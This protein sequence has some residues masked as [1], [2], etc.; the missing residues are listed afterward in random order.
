MM[1]AWFS[2]SAC[3]SAFACVASIAVLLGSARLSRSAEFHVA[4][5]DV[6]GL[7]SAITDATSNGEDDI[8]NLAPGSTYNLSQFDNSTN[9]NAANGLPVLT[10]DGGRSLT[11]NGNGATISCVYQ[12][13]GTPF[14]AL[15]VGPSAIVTLNRLTISGGHLKGSSSSGGG[16][17]LN[18]RGQLTLSECTLSGNGVGAIQA[19]DVT[20]LLGGAIYNARGTLTLRR[21]TFF[22]NSVRQF[23]TSSSSARAAGGAIYNADGVVTALLCTFVNNRAEIDAGSGG[24]S[25]GASGGAI[26]NAVATSAGEARLTIASCTFSDNYA[27]A[28]QSSPAMPSA[29]GNAIRNT[30]AR[31]ITV[32]GSSILASINSSNSVVSNAGGVV[33]SSGFNLTSGTAEGFFTAG[34]DQINA[35]PQLRPIADNGG[36]TRTCAPRITSPV[37][38]RG[39]RDAVPELTAETDQR[40][41]GRPID[42]SGAEFAPGDGSDI[43]AHEAQPTLV[44]TTTSDHPDDGDCSLADCTLREAIRAANQAPNADTIAFASGVSGTINLTAALPDLATDLEIAGPGADRLTVRRDTGGNYRIFTVS[45]GTSPG[46]EIGLADLTLSNGQGVG[47]ATPGGGIQ[48]VSGTLRL[49]RCAI[50]GNNAGNGAGIHN[51][52]GTVSVMN[53]TFS[54][55]TAS[56]FGGALFNASTDNYSDLALINCTVVGNTSGRGAALY[57][58]AN[59]FAPRVVLRSCTFAGNASP[60]GSIYHAGTTATLNLNNTILSVPSGTASIVIVNSAKVTSEGHNISSDAAGGDGSTG[61]GGRLTHASDKRN[62]DPLLDPA[63]LQDNGGPTL[64]LALQANSPAIDTGSSTNALASDQR[65]FTRSG[66]VD[67][68]AFEFAGVEP[69][70]PP[71]P[72]PSPSATPA[73]TATPPPNRFA[74]IS[75]R[76]RVETGDNVLIGGFIVTGSMQKRIIVRALGPSLPLDDKLANPVL[77]LYDGNAQLIASNDNWQEAPNAQEIIDSTIPP[78]NEFESAI[79]R[80]VDLGAYTAVVRDAAGGEGVGL[81]EVYDL[82]NAQDSELANISTRGRV[83]TAD[84]VMIGGLIATG[85]HAQKVIL[86]AI[87]PSLP[88]A[89]RLEN[90]LLELYDGNGNL[91]SANDNWKDSQQADIEATTIPPS[92]DFESA[93]V[94]FLPPAAYTAIV[95]G[96]NDTTGVALVEVYGLQ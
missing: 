15:Q 23:G 7:K 49:A 53:S 88:V 51:S 58:Q 27:F 42:I 54:G 24:I 48:N 12:V 62:T 50:V 30:G 73:P 70:P 86:R 36:A 47:S 14:R 13:N 35:D 34:G 33:T 74:N 81:V 77:E 52:D 45:N 32:I 67:I 10:A 43:G 71:T 39:R 85:S 95:R 17:I 56:G 72:T 31:A 69:T 3:R 4:P 64:T 82:G 25:P 59:S 84:N 61:P 41:V 46:P 37:I 16:A 20:T 83:L 6:T 38:D 92:N 2:I 40:G 26:E 9:S 29:S 89:G 63:G 5:A 55:N 80:N 76:L 87:G 57:N 8:I 60:L 18:D 90:P 79:L 65:E 66:A 22:S 93:I 19:P 78:P 28:P 91:M 44:V 21:S 1:S 11:I 96:V 75:T 94:A 68:G